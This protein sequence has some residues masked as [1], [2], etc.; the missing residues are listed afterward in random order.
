[1]YIHVG[2]KEIAMCPFYT[3]IR[4]GSKQTSIVMRLLDFTGCCKIMILSSL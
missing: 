2:H 4:E 3:R 1:M